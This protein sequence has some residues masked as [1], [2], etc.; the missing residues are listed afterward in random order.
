MK[1]ACLTGC[2][3]CCNT[4]PSV[5]DAD[6]ALVRYG[7]GLLDAEARSK[8]ASKIRSY[9]DRIDAIDPTLHEAYSKMRSDRGSVGSWIRYVT[10]GSSWPRE[11]IP[12]PLLGEDH[13]CTIYAY[14][15]VECAALW[16]G[17]RGCTDSITSGDL[18]DARSDL[19]RLVHGLGL[20]RL[21]WIEI[22]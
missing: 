10:G 21:L 19:Q 8:I 17:D 3:H 13:R 2:S 5:F 20:E 15:P 22:A 1:S 9:A 6:V 14:R 18:I 11:G 4:I 7:I 16:M 12:C